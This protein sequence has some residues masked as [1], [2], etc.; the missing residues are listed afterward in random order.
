MFEAWTEKTVPFFSHPSGVGMYGSHQDAAHTQSEVDFVS[1]YVS[2]R[3]TVWDTCCGHGRHVLELAHRGIQTVGTDVDET[4]IS[5]GNA[6]LEEAGLR[7]VGELRHDDAKTAIVRCDLAMCLNTSIGYDGPAADRRT[8]RNIYQNL[9]PGG[10]FVVHVDNRDCALPRI[11]DATWYSTDQQLT[12]EE[13]AYDALLN[14][15]TVRHL[16][17]RRDGTT[18]RSETSVYLYT[19][20]ELAHLVQEA[21]FIIA[22]IYGSYDGGRFAISGTDIIVVGRK[23]E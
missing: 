22:D 18:C 1:R 10:L 12:I 14:R 23:P 7:S 8:F 20:A 9:S 11:E 5:Y 15:L 17:I 6:A 16:R 2:Q 3:S 19:F 21:G 13:R 4:L